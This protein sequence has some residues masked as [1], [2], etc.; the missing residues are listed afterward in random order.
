MN[1]PNRLNTEDKLISS[2]LVSQVNNLPAT[3]RSK[4][5]GF[6]IETFDQRFKNRINCHF[7]KTQF[8][9]NIAENFYTCECV[10]DHLTY[11]CQDCYENCHT[12]KKCN[13][14][15]IREFKQEKESVDAPNNKKEEKKEIEKSSVTCYCGK[16]RHEVPGWNTETQ[17][18]NNSSPKN[19]VAKTHK[20]TDTLVGL[21]SEKDNDNKLSPD[22][23]LNENVKS[24]CIY[25]D[26]IKYCFPRF[27]YEFTENNMQIRKKTEVEVLKHSKSTLG[28][29]NPEKPVKVDMNQ[30]KKLNAIKKQK[31]EKPKSSY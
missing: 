19:S 28:M 11:I 31:K 30:L 20:K 27:I 6:E 9:E 1:E 29:N 15:L 24:S 13:K 3:K 8:N 18:D 5:L 14:Y 2:E 12:S 21:L 7:V 25:E 10:G 16:F 4:L 22:C 26:I 23:Q 17:I